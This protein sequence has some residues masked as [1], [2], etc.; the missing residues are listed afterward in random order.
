[1]SSSL[2]SFVALMLN[3]GGCLIMTVLV[4]MITFIS[5]LR[6]VRLNTKKGRERERGEISWQLSLLFIF[7][8]IPEDYYLLDKVFRYNKK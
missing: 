3:A 7:T 6:K 4:V 2:R 5:L 8:S 1:M